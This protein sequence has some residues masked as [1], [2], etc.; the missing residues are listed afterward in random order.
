MTFAQ[1]MQNGVA[2]NQYLDEENSA[3]LPPEIGVG[4]CRSKFDFLIDSIA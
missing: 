1:F 3:Y 2:Y 4:T